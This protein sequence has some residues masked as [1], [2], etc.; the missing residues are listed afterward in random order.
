MKLLEKK[1]KA[2]AAETE[3]GASPAVTEK[4]PKSKKRRV[5]CVCGAVVL[6]LAA[7]KIVPSF[8]GGVSDADFADGGASK[9]LPVP[10]GDPSG[11]TAE[12]NIYICI[13]VMNSASYR[14][15]TT[16]STA[17]SV[18][19]ID[20]NQQIYGQRV[21]T[22]DSVFNETIST[23]A[24]VKVGEQKYFKDG[25][26]LMRKAD[27]VSGT[28]AQWSKDIY[29]ISDEDY[30]HAYGQLPRNLTN[31]VVS[32]ETVCKPEMQKDADGNFVIS[33]DLEP[34]G[35]SAYYKRQIYTYSGASQMP[36][37]TEVHMVWTIDS[38]WRL[39]K[40]ETV[41]T[42]EVTMSG[43][44]SMGCTSNITELFS[45]FGNVTDDQK[46]FQKY[47]ETEYD[48]DKLSKL[49]RDDA[50]QEE[51]LGIFERNPNLNVTVTAGG[52]QYVLKAH[53][54][55][56]NMSFKV[57]GEVEGLDV[58]GVYSGGKLYLRVENQKIVLKADDTID[59]FGKVMG[60]LGMKVPDISLEGS[61]VQSIV[62]GMDVKTTSKGKTISFNDSML[63]GA[64]K[65]TGKEK[66]KL[67]SAD[68]RVNVG[69]TSVGIYATPAKSFNSE[70]LSGYTDL[71]G[72]LTLVSPIMENVSS[73][74]CTADVTVSGS[75][76]SLSGRLRVAYPG[77]ELR[78]IFDTSVDGV[79][80]RV[81]LVGD[82][83]YAEAGNIRISGRLGQLKD[84][85]GFITE[86]SGGSASSGSN[87]G[88]AIESFFGDLSVKKAINSVSGLSWYDNAL[89]ASVNLG[90]GVV[91]NAALGSGSVSLEMSGMRINM[92][93]VS[94]GA[95]SISAPTGSFVTLSQLAQY[96]DTLLRYAGAKG[97]EMAADV[98]VNG[99]AIH[100]DMI[101]DFGS[102]MAVKASSKLLGTQ[103][104]V[105]LY[106]GTVYIDYGAIRVRADESNLRQAMETALKLV[107]GL[108]SGT[109]AKTVG[110]YVE[111]FDNLSLARV[112]GAISEFYFA[113]GQLH[114]TASI[115]DDPLYL[116]LTPTAVY[117]STTVSGTA[118]SAVLTPGA[119]LKEASVLAP[120]GYYMSVDELLAAGAIFR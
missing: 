76:I 116:S 91:V 17:A 30:S 73:G 112:V 36:V 65:I 11:Q 37:F 69:G 51:L 103:L 42:Y 58:Y 45:D 28:T 1:K 87:A 108:G 60:G 49:S 7:I 107:P 106:N 98:T 92:T 55:I 26:I 99:V 32:D 90:G 48:P 61:A 86:M 104:N 14:S 10:E 67:K 105:T 4:K 64:I 63:S 115:A 6:L 114:I 113:D 50:L 102:P 25:A 47:L 96:K 3:E 41:E 82:T 70:S 66:P 83:V 95:P 15:E 18:G 77:S 44:G 29:A 89:H 74:G 72:A 35:A 57:K 78:A 52:K 16:G 80:V 21:V 93:L 109:L 120:S 56:A 23:S 39:L 54:D 100:A 84:L 75:G 8:F 43:L 53:L 111:F 59:A 79:A 5:L 33:F 20:Y 19:F 119:A 46:E 27:S 88:A 40:M 85:V 34:E 13:G 118:V 9:T 101:F 110:A 71:T 2:D 68:L 62:N 12:D 22:E 38:Q 24:L 31:Y 81:T 94:N 97:M 117:A